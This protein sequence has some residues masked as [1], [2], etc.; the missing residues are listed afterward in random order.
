[1]SSFKFSAIHTFDKTKDI[2]ELEEVNALMFNSKELV[3]FTKRSEIQ[4]ELETTL[5]QSI[6]VR[7]NSRL[8]LLR[9]IKDNYNELK[10]K[11]QVSDKVKEHLIYINYELLYDLLDLLAP[12]QKYRLDSCLD[13]KPTFHL[14]FR[15]TTAR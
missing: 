1:L 7:S 13:T 11:A 2:P 12:F 8:L 6:D 5:K 9:S 15:D 4:R 10:N 14:G 3:K